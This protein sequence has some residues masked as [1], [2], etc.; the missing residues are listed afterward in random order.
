MRGLLVVL[1]LVAMPIA[2]SG[3]DV[4]RPDPRAKS[5]PPVGLTE[6]F[7]FVPA[8]GFVDDPVGTDGKRV[9]FVVADTAGTAEL[10]VVDLA[11]SELAPPI[12]LA[13][14]T[15]KPTALAFIGDRVL[16]IGG[17]TDAQL[18]A[19]VDLKTK[20]IVY[21][22]PPVNRA[23]LVVRDGKQLVALYKREPS[24]VGT[25]HTVEL[26]AAATGKR[27]GKVKTLEVDGTDKHAKLEFR[28]NHWVN[29]F[30]RAVGIKGGTWNKQEDQR[31]PD[32]EA[33]YDV[34]TGK[35]LATSPIPDLVAQRKRFS[36]LAAAEGKDTFV[37]LK[38]DLSEIELWQDGTRTAV[39]LDQ[40]LVAYGDP[41]RSLDLA[42]GPKGPWIALQ[43][44][45]VNV[46][47]VK[48]QKADI[49]YWDLFE[50][51]G[52][53]K[54]TRRGR[55]FAGGQRFRFGFAGD[56]LWVLER[57]VGFD[58]GGKALVFYTLP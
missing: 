43:V 5:A 11:G 1:G 45:P 30:T 47:A 39:T 53:T 37:R 55:L 26:R 22:T 27:V 14:V 8:A 19:L 7:R 21:R 31:S 33:T 40:P 3:D 35:F 41:R 56:R 20:K 9:A 46:E 4:K 6:A 51:D 38:E 36:V 17:E 48:R 57:N 13:A 29:G 49:E 12:D 16:V 42:A 25:R 10:R 2:A 52:G 28:I 32:V 50:V 58:R 18:A 23:T 54:A 44:D 34:I 24:K 15:L